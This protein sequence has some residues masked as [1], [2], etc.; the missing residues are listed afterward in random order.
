M[1]TFAVK[2]LITSWHRDS[3]EFRLGITST[4]YYSEMR[5]SSIAYGIQP[6]ITLYLNANDVITPQLRFPEGAGYVYGPS[7][8]QIFKH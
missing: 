3:L 5:A 6:S 1:Y 4:N 2:K 8:L 7:V